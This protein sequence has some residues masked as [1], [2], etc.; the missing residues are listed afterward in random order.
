MD[1]NITEN[2][3]NGYMNRLHHTGQLGQH[4]HAAYVAAVEYRPHASAAEYRSSLRGGRNITMGIGKDPYS[5]GRKIARGM[6]TKKPK[7]EV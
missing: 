3:V 1:V 2:C 6:R 4:I 5:Y 7:T